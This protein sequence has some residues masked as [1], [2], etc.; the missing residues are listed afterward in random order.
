[1]GQKVSDVLAGPNG[2]LCLP[3]LVKHAEMGDMCVVRK[4]YSTNVTLSRSFDVFRVRL[5][6]QA[7]QHITRTEIDDWREQAEL[8]CRS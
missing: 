3:L 2:R 8:K 6:R 5:C 4:R 7:A 1:M